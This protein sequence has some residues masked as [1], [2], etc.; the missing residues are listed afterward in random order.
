MWVQHV[1]WGTKESIYS[2]DWE[3]QE[4]RVLRLKHRW[5]IIPKLTLKKGDV[6]VGVG[7]IVSG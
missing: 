3:P 4:S 6:K 2:I 5:R 1:A 7:L